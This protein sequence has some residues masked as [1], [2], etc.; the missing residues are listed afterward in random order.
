M[1]LT[2]D[3]TIDNDQ[4]VDDT[5]RISGTAIRDDGR[6]VPPYVEMILT[7]LRSISLSR[8]I[9]LMPGEVGK[10]SWSGELTKASYAIECQSPDF[11]IKSLA[12]DGA[13]VRGKTIEVRGGGLLTLA[14]VFTSNSSQVKGKVVNSGR[15]VAGA[16]VLMVPQDFESNMP[17]FRRDESDSDGTFLLPPVP[18][19]NYIAV[20]LE[21]GWEIEWAKPEVLKP[22]LAKGQ[23]V[24]LRSAATADI[25]LEL[26]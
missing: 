20:A 10:F 1:E 26:Q 17:F 23:P 7:P 9:P 19:G 25:I 14:V 13:K 24:R 22:Y 12:T 15:P 16:L 6:P 21:H 2:A 11:S 18:P 8:R 5:A 4:V 3:I